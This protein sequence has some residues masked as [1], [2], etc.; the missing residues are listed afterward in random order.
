M[1]RIIVIL[2]S[3]FCCTSLFAEPL[4]EIV[5]LGDS[6]SDNG[7][8]YAAL[9]VIP[10]SPPYYKGRFTNG[11]TWAEDVGKYYYEKSYID[12]SIYAWG[13]A[14][15]IV[16]NP[17]HDKFVA[18]MVLEEEVYSYLTKS[19]TTDKSK[20]LYVIWIGANDYLYDEQPDI[21]ALTTRV[22]DKI[23]WAMNTLMSHGAQHFLIMNLPDLSRTPFAAVGHTEERLNALTLM[24]NQKLA[25]AVKSFGDRNKNVSVASIDIFSIFNDMLDHTEK[26]NQQY[27]VNIQ[28][29]TDSCWGGG[30]TANTH[31]NS[32][33]LSSDL[34]KALNSDSRAASNVI[35]NSPTLALAYAMGQSYESGTTPCDHAEQY[36]FWDELHPTETVHSVLAKIVEQIL[37][38]QKILN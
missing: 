14:T 34:Q 35:L 15:A 10:K 18:P 8:L 21:N 6:L 25:D 23:S 32:M 3:L 28:N 26:Y 12:Y 1:K 7:N 27:N 24:H 5:V 2:L 19:M 36:V 17:A 33:A 30:M 29:K 31:A 13:G 20:V 11:F 4:K 16:H 9:K 22:V 38:N 37:D